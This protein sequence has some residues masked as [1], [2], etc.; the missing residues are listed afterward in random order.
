MI[1]NA[2]ISFLDEVTLNLNV[3]LPLFNPLCFCFWP[4]LESVKQF[5]CV[6][7]GFSHRSSLIILEA[8]LV[9]DCFY[10][11]GRSCVSLS[12]HALAYYLVPIS[13][14]VYDMTFVLLWLFL[15]TTTSITTSVSTPR[16]RI[17]HLQRRKAISVISLLGLIQFSFVM[18]HEPLVSAV[19]LKILSAATFST[20]A[21][22]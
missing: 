2:L 10:V 21:L 8:T 9:R 20:F 7:T 3:K 17:V 16:L 13:S 19:L 22:D 18:E 6:F 14:D 15:E 1:V 5:L 4:R 11:S 12:W